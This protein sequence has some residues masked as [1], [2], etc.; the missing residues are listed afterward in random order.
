MI[1]K[2]FSLRAMCYD[3]NQPLWGA[4]FRGLTAVKYKYSIFEKLFEIW[5]IVAAYT[6]PDVVVHTSPDQHKIE[7][8]YFY[9]PA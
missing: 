6:W 7:E 8:P 2:V 5:T 9:E 1:M 4:R 3:E